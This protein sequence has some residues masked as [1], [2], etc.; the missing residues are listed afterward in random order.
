M[1]LIRITVSRAEELERESA[2][3]LKFKFVD[4]S[5][6]GITLEGPQGPIFIELDSYTLSVSELA[7][8]QVYHLAFFHNVL[9]ENHFIEKDFD[10]ET[11]RDNYI[12]MHLSDVPPD[13]LVL[14]TRTIL[15]E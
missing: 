13:E 14:E 6:K 11:A 3:Y 5:I 8:K 9:G 2:G 1:K 7:R 12:A 15:E 4:G 10:S